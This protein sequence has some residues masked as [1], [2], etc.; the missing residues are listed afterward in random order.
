MAEHTWV[1][2]GSARAWGWRE[3]RTAPLPGQK[4]RHPEPKGSQ[5][6]TKAAVAALDTDFLR[7]GRAWGPPL[8][9]PPETLR[10][11]P[12]GDKGGPPRLRC[13]LQHPYSLC[14]LAARRLRLLRLL[15]TPAGRQLAPFVSAGQCPRRLPQLAQPRTP[16][17]QVPQN[18]VQGGRQE[19]PKAG[20]P[21]LE[22]PKGGG[23]AGEERETRDEGWKG[24][25]KKGR[26]A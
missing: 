17:P 14:A 23:S 21:T 5:P 6:T 2:C 10:V 24:L 25:G 18:S 15:N 11:T 1:C 8:P 19:S 20:S 4:H 7:P 13:G 3:T 22:S 9:S 12:P 16:L 26:G